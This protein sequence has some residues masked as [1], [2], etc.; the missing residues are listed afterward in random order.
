MEL[1]MT[2]ATRGLDDLD[3]G[4]GSRIQPRDRVTISEDD[5]RRPTSAPPDLNAPGRVIEMFEWERQRIA[6]INA[7]EWARSIVDA[8][9]NLQEGW[10]S[11]GAMTVD[12]TAADL[13]EQLLAEMRR[14]PGLAI[15]QAAPSPDGGVSIEWHRTNLDLVISIGPGDEPPS[16]YFADAGQEW[17]IDDLREVTDGR[18]DAALDALISR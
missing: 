15:P 13:A 18:F 12:S 6:E 2:L 7:R 1:R 11:Y 16:A 4:S 17:E 3:F 9:R 5:V 14:I 10:D 8:F